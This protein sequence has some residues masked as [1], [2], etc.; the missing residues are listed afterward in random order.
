MSDITQILQAIEN[1]D[2]KV[3]N[4][5][6]KLCFFVGLTQEEAAHELGRS[7]STAERVCAFSVCALIRIN[8]ERRFPESSCERMPLVA[9]QRPMRSPNCS[10]GSI[11]VLL[12]ALC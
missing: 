5:L 6:V 4:E 10:L 7:L 3:A 9:N 11:E 2:A 8:D 1:G 12:L